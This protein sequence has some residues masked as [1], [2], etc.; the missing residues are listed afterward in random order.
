MALSL[1]PLARPAWSFSKVDQ[2]LVGS[3]TV[4][5]VSFRCGTSAL[6]SQIS[7]LQFPMILPVN[8]F[9]SPRFS[10]LFRVSAV[11]IRTATELQFPPE[12]AQ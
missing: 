12:N 1:T 11:S 3:S 5:T 10:P 8:D 4:S 7:N 2:P 6:K 9:A